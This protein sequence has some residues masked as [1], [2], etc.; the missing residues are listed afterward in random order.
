MCVQYDTCTRTDCPRHSFHLKHACDRKEG[1]FHPLPSLNNPSRPVE[2]CTQSPHTHTSRTPLLRTRTRSLKTP[3]HRHTHTSWTPLLRTRTRSLRTPCH[4]HTQ[5]PS[6]QAVGQLSPKPDTA[7]KI[8][9]SVEPHRPSPC[10][11]IQLAT[12]W[13]A[14]LSIQLGAASVRFIFAAVERAGIKVDRPPPV[15]P[16]LIWGSNLG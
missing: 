10:N 11:T 16:A 1:P 7:L 4:R 3:C 14:P 6:S 8:C 2:A 12:P 5:T 13:P 15:R 9:T